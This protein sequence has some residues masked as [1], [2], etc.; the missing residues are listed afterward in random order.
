MKKAQKRT[1]GQIFLRLLFILYGVAMLWLLFG[2]RIGSE[3]FYGNYAVQLEN[4][5]NLTPF[6]TI[7]LYLRLLENST[8]AALLRHSVI[9]LVGNVVMFI[10]LGIFLPGIFI[11]KANFFKFF[12]V[13]AVMIV[14]VE[15]V[16]L[17]TL[18]GSC[19]VD[20]LILNLAGA[21][22]GYMLWKIHTLRRKR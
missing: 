7:K 15:L 10:P 3:M 19:D 14:L 22:I 20:D 13:V 5:I 11:K 12:L 4:N 2:Q 16:Q 9:N 6:V 1:A 8:N 17:F 18:L 21:I